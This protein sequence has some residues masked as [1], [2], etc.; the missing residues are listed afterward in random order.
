MNSVYL[1]NKTADEVLQVLR[2]SLDKQTFAEIYT[3]EQKEWAT[4]ADANSLARFHLNDTARRLVR[5]AFVGHTAMHAIIMPGRSFSVGSPYP[6][7]IAQEAAPR[8]FVFHRT[9]LG[10]IFPRSLE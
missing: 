5:V 4:T 8:V 1:F 2:D 7:K 6:S 10:R 3:T 9:A